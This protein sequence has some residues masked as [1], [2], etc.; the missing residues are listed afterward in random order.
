MSDDPLAASPLEAA[1][2]GVRADL[3]RGLGFGDAHPLAAAAKTGALFSAEM[4]GAPH[5]RNDTLDPPPP[6]LLR[7]ELGERGGGMVACTPV[8]YKLANS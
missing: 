1:C 7:S 3:A 6:K 5:T 8:V 2:L 4:V